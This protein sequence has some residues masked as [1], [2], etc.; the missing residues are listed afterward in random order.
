[1]RHAL[2]L[3]PGERGGFLTS[4]LAAG[5]YAANRTG[6]A[7]SALGVGPFVLETDTRKLWWMRM[8]LEGRPTD[9]AGGS[10]LIRLPREVARTQKTWRTVAQPSGYAA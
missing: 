3:A 1:M 10:A 9:I 2:G 4:L 5:R 8:M 6:V 7:T